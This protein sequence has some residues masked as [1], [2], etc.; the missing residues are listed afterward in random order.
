M[1]V[2]LMTVPLSL[3]MSPVI[4][5]AASKQAKHFPRRAK[6]WL[7]TTL[8]RRGVCTI[9]V[10][11]E[12]ERLLWL[13][14]SFILVSHVMFKIQL[15]WWHHHNWCNWVADKSQCHCNTDS[16]LFWQFGTGPSVLSRDRWRQVFW[17]ETVAHNVLLVEKCPYFRGS[18]CTHLYV[19]A[20]VGTVLIR[21]VSLF[22]R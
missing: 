8:V 12:L 21:E 18:F 11:C 10:S 4:A 19:A 5:A 9:C 13:K 22:Q 3:L 15:F 2:A 17:V 7:F 1:M 20:T 14:L 6:L 16:F